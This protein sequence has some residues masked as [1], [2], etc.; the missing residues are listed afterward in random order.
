MWRHD[1]SSYGS[2][3]TENREKSFIWVIQ[4]LNIHG[5]GRVCKV[6]LFEAMRSKIQF[7]HRKL[8]KWRFSK[9]VG[10][11]KPLLLVFRE[12]WQNSCVNIILF[13]SDQCVTNKYF[14]MKVLSKFW[15]K[16][17]SWCTARFEWLKNTSVCS[18][19]NSIWYAND[20][21]GG[22]GK[23][24]VCPH[25]KVSFPFLKF[26]WMIETNELLMHSGQ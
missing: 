22:Y 25:F 9:L 14:D 20:P 11:C 16:M 15:I 6:N 12:C 8:G 2:C 19:E 17:L 13:K 1:R 21:I 5:K 7:K 18:M 4:A 26:W 10:F 3:W 23:L 24:K